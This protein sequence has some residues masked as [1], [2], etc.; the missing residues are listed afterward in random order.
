MSD[1]SPP[2]QSELPDTSVQDDTDVPGR[3]QRERRPTYKALIT[4]IQAAEKELNQLWKMTQQALRQTSEPTTADNALAIVKEAKNTLEAYH[5]CW[6]KLEK[7]YDQDESLKEDALQARTTFLENSN[8]ANSSIAQATEWAYSLALETKSNFSGR[9]RCTEHSLLSKSSKASSSSSCSAKAQAL[10]AA[11]AAA[12]NA[13]YEELIAR[14]SSELVAQQAARELEQVRRDAEARVE[15]ARRELEHQTLQAAAE[16]DIQILKAKQAAAIERARSEAITQADQEENALLTSPN[17]TSNDHASLFRSSNEAKT[18]PTETCQLRPSA[19]EFK[20]ATEQSPSPQNSPLLSTG[21]TQSTEPLGKQSADITLVSLT[22]DITDTLARQRQPAHEPDIYGGDPIMFQPWLSSFKTMISQAQTPSTQKLAFLAKYTKGEVRQLVDR[23]RHRYV[24]NPETAYKEALKELEER[25]GDKTKIT[26]QIIKKLHDFPKIKTDE[27]RKL[28]EL[29]DLCANTAAQMDD[30]TGLQI[31]NYS[32]NTHPILE[33]LPTYI[34]NAWRKRASEYKTSVG[35]YPPFSMLAKFIKEKARIQND[36]ELY[37]SPHLNHKPERAPARRSPSS[38]LRVMATSTP[39]KS[40]STSQTVSR[41]LYH[42]KQGHHISECIAFRREPMKERREFCKTKGLCYKCGDNHRVKD[43]N[44]KVQCKKCQSPNHATFMHTI[45]KENAGEPS[46]DP[47]ADKPKIEETNTK[48]TKFLSC[49]SAR[50]CSKIVL[51]KLY[52][53]DRPSRSILGY[54]VLDD[55][56]NAC[57]A[58]PEVFEA[59]E[60]RGPSFPYELSTCGGSKIMTEGRRASGIVVESPEGK[61]E[62]LPTVIENAHIPGDKKEIPCPEVCAKF[63]HLKSIATKVP[64][65]RDDVNIILLIGRSCPEPLKI[66]ESRNGPKGTP[67]PQCTDLGWTVSGQI[68][69]AGENGRLHAT[70]NRTVIRPDTCENH[71]NVKDVL[72]PPNFAT[73][74]TD[75]YEETCDD[76]LRAMSIED[77]RFIKILSEGAHINASGNLEFP[78]PLKETSTKL[79]NNYPQALRRLNNV[80]RTLKHKPEM[81]A[82]YVAYFDKLLTRGHASPVPEKELTCQPDKVWYLPHFPVRHPKKPDIRVVFDASAEYHNVSLN[83]ALLQGPDQMNGLLGILLRFRVG[84]VAIMGDIEQMFHNFH[85]NKEHRDFLRFLWFESNDP[86]KQIAQ[87]RMNVHLFGNVS[88]P[89]VA[90]FGLR[91]IANECQQSHGQDVLDFVRRDF[92]VDDG[93]TSCPDTQSAVSLIRRTS[94]A[95]ATRKVRFHKIASNDKDVMK[96]LPQDAQAKDLRAL[97]L[98]RDALPTQRSLGVYWSLERDTFTF[99]INLDDKPFTRRGVLSVTSSIYDPMGLATPVTIE[100]KCILRQLI[101]DA[102][103]E[104]SKPQDVWDRPLPEKHLPR[105]T[106]WHDS[107]HHLEKIHLPRCFQPQQFGNAKRREIHIFSDASEHAIGAV[108][109]LKL[110]NDCDRPHVSFLLAKARVTPQHAVSIP[111]LELCGAVLATELAKIIQSEFKDRM[112]IDSTSFYTDS[113]IVLSYI[114]NESKRFHV[115]VANRV[116]KIHTMSTPNQWH[117]VPTDENPA[118][119]AS[120]SVPA[121]QLNATMWFRGPNFLWNQE[122]TSRIVE[123]HARDEFLVNQ[124]DPEVRKESRVIHTSVEDEAHGSANTKNGQQLG[125]SRFSRF[126]SWTTLLRAVSTL[127]S[128]VK[129]FKSQNDET[130]KNPPRQVTSGVLQQAEN[131]ILRAVQNEYFHDETAALKSGGTNALKKDSPLRKLSPFIDEDGIIRVGGRLRRADLDLGGR[132]PVLLPKSSHISILVIRHFYHEVQHQGRHLTLA[133]VRAGGKWIIGAHDLVRSVI[134]RCTVCRKL[135]GK[136]LTQVMADLPEDRLQATPPFTNVGMDVFGPWS[137]ITRKTRGGS[138]EAKRW[139]VLF[140]CLCTRAV[141]VE[142]IE[143]MDTSALISALRRFCSLRGPIARLRCDR[144]TNF[145]GAEGTLNQEQVAR[146]LTSKNCEWI[147]NPPKAS[148]F[149]GI[150]E[151]QIGIIRRVLD[152]MFIQLGKHQLTHDVLIT[153]MA[154]ACAIVNSRPI[155]TIS[156]DANDPLPLTPAMLL[157]LKSHPVDAPPGNFVKEDLYGRQHWRRVQYLANQFW[158][159]WRKEYLQSLQPRQKWTQTTPDLSEGDVVILRQKELPRNRWPLARVTKTY[160]SDDSR[161][162]KVDIVICVDGTRR[163]YLRPISELVLLERASDSK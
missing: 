111:R 32:F 76:N 156:S 23:F 104:P 77:Q 54:V 57:L 86:S 91:M 5:E 107:L 52:H 115:Y 20:P 73:P 75:L 97:D 19:P 13:T 53:K 70:V 1:Q 130:D 89:A 143:A 63:P 80:V 28:L 6:N 22:K 125:C 135:R 15:H 139:A 61:T 79:P 33:K 154:E 4:S 7:L 66:R 160:P 39:A 122:D 118:D 42:D 146:Y 144:G 36:P 31:L 51:C 145:I 141:H 9:S 16:A 38:S 21:P 30:L 116:H 157:T 44:T 64:E 83:K 37:P 152:S 155:T 47:P 27:H 34:H 101:T 121:S 14:R 43:C 3:P 159:R 68:C 90:T 127:I 46:V 67:W 161:V 40:L 85:V 11:A 149:G 62:R 124:E 136:P 26:T 12:E 112:S 41:C 56:S 95:L 108:A 69:M 84:E 137:V 151:R 102:K 65:I 49:S 140:T 10:A 134:N 25:F 103:G 106:R 153:F 98:A 158:T 88:S 55:Q 48:C 163:T 81:K 58:D 109:Y 113:K 110:I 71:I 138:A 45:P 148:H 93:L 100:G 78:L 94:D 2:V 150:W 132:H 120:R 114:S 131:V 18:P 92:Y 162:R 8:N 123:I 87:Y 126:S 133:S 29:A 82:E 117:H 35:T 50:S 142:V 59:L 119:L 72:S 74:T 147:F 99:Q 24:A 105:W 128:H 129:G 96:S 60:L 17:Q